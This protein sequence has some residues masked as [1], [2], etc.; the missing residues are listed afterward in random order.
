MR[1]STIAAK[2]WNFFFVKKVR[3]LTI[4]YFLK[5]C[6]C[7]H[8]TFTKIF[9][10]NKLKL[11]KAKGPDKKLFCKMKIIS[12]EVDASTLSL[13]CLPMYAR[14]LL[15][16]LYQNI[17]K[18]Y[19]QELREGKLTL[20]KWRITICT[21]RQCH[22]AAVS[23]EEPLW[24]LLLLTMGTSHSLSMILHLFGWKMSQQP[25]SRPAW[26]KE[27][28]ALEVT[29]PSTGLHSKVLNRAFI[30]EK[31]VSAYL[32]LEQNAT[33]SHFLR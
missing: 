13:W 9:L 2:I 20:S 26:C 4:C 10:R 7:S 27:D 28:G 5:I 14:G 8:Q 1:L 30:M 23:P 29:P 12:F 3:N 18:F 33:G 25:V 24:Y 17:L 32:Q 22:L 21:A 11:L 15:S 16:E 6:S 31:P 19:S